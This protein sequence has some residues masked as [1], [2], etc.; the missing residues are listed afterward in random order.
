MKWIARLDELV[1]RQWEP[2]E[3]VVFD[4][5]SGDT[6]LLNEFAALTLR[7]FESGPLSTDEVI[8]RVSLIADAGSAADFRDQISALLHFFDDLGLIDA[9][10]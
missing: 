7:Q 1:W 10:P 8:Q 5:A 4:A 2:G 6:H 9:A 3:H